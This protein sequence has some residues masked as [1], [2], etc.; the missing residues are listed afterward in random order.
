MVN[1]WQFDANGNRTHENGTQVATYDAQDRL[2]QYGDNQYRYSANGELTRKTNAATGNTTHYDYDAFSNL[3]SVI[4]PDGTE[5][6]YV[7]DGQNRRT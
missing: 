5:I 6:D 2:T 7:I 4:L 3:R 1:A